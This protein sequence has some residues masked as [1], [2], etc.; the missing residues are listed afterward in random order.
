MKADTEDMALV[1][2]DTLLNRLA[3]RTLLFNNS[4]YAIAWESGNLDLV[5]QAAGVISLDSF[6][7][8]HLSQFLRNVDVGGISVALRDEDIAEAKFALIDGERLH[9]FSHRPNLLAE[10]V[11]RLAQAARRN[12]GFSD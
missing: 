12:R 4:L 8:S 11:D 6:M 9:I 7:G 5:A 10:D 2:V 3:G 1:D